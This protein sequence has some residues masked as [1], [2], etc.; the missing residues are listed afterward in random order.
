MGRRRKIW[1]MKKI[2]IGSHRH[3]PGSSQV[4]KENAQSYVSN[5]S[6]FQTILVKLIKFHHF[7]DIRLKIWN[8]ILSVLTALECKI[9]Q[10]S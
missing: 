5:M 2:V 4:S 10:L 3:F 1:Q 9:L 6:N 8:I 7:S